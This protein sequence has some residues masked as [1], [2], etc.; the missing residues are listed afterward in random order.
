MHAN[1]IGAGIAGPMAAITLAENGYE[2]DVYDDRAKADLRSD[3]VLGITD[4]SWEILTAHG[5]V[6]AQ[7]RQLPNGGDKYHYLVWTDLHTSLV[8]RAEQLGASFHYGQAFEADGYTDLNVWATGVGSAK[9]VTTG[10]YTGYVIVRGLAYQFSGSSWTALQEKSPEGEWLF[11]AGDTREGTAITMF[12]PR[13]NVTLRTTYSQTPPFEV[14]RLPLRWSR[15]LETV[16]LWQLAP[17]SDW[18]VPGNLIVG[19]D[20]IRIGDANGQLRPKTSMGA[21][22]A[23]AEGSNVEL[24]VHQSAEAEH[25]LLAHRREFHDVGI[26][27]GI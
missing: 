2:V 8:E 9:Q 16:P 26:S 15:L 20:V 1:I 10:H 17:M 14:N 18:D 25:R 5:V 19:Q 24:L 11:T 27:A 12:V 7:R 3:G 4:D 23:L 6:G 22:R 21:N 13:K